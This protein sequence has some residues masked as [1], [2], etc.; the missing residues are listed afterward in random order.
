M[1]N[2]VKLYHKKGGQMKE[3]TYIGKIDK[4]KLGIL[5]KQIITEEIILTEERFQHILE[6]EIKT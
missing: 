2:S 3:Y 1:K 4:S 5:R 6:L